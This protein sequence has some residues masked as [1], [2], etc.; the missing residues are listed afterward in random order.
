[1]N[2]SEKAILRALEDPRLTT[3]EKALINKRLT[4]T[5]PHPT[6]SGMADIKRT[7]LGGT[8]QSTPY[9]GRQ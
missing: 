2:E 5:M 4:G 3:G 9:R 7:T 6:G 1:M 8:Y